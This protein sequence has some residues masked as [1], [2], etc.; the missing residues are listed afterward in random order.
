MRLEID[1][2]ILRLYFL[3]FRIYSILNP[4]LKIFP[5]DVA[6]VHRLKGITGL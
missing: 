2:L 3:K 4:D 5:E 6:D 1:L